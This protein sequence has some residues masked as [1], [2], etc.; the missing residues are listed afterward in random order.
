MTCRRVPPWAARDRSEAQ[1]QPTVSLSCCYLKMRIHSSCVDRPGEKARWMLSIVQLIEVF[2]F[3]IKIVLVRALRRCQWFRMDAPPYL[4]SGW[5]SQRLRSSHTRSCSHDSLVINE[6]IEVNDGLLG[7][8]SLSTK[9]WLCLGYS[10]RSCLP[11]RGWFRPYSDLEASSLAWRSSCSIKQFSDFWKHLT[12]WMG[13]LHFDVGGANRNSSMS[14]FQRIPR[15][16][17][18]LSSSISKK[19]AR[20]SCSLGKLMSTALL[21]EVNLRNGNPAVPRAR[22]WLGRHHF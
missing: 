16:Y 6:L 21:L 19:S 22:R 15:V 11:W 13:L 8:T 17:A 5:N 7:I 12:F 20:S 3:S 10:V 2:L 4:I 14:D 18:R 9:P 1:W